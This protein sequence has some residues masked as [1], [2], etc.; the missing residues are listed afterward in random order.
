MTTELVALSIEANDPERQA[1]FWGDLLGWEPADHDDGLAVADH[2]PAIV[3][4]DGTGFRIH[5]PPTDAPKVGQ[6]W[7][8]V[9]L[10]S[11]SLDDQAHQ[12]AR[13]LELGG[14]HVDIGQ[15]PDDGHVV[16]ADPEGNELC[17]I[18]PGNTFLA[19]CPFI[20]ALSC[21]GS[22]AVG[23]FWS[24]ALGWPLVWDQD[25]ETAIQ[26]PHGGPKISWGGPPLNPRL[27][28][29]GIH[30]DLAVPPGDDVRLE[31]DRLVSL[32]ATPTG[33][34]PADRRS[35]LLED[36]DGNGFCVV[37]GARP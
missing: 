22:Q 21:D 4:T 32:G 6:N 16:L 37:E 27:G 10:T 14:R 7:L 13:V 15:D 29:R 33:R 30:L 20:G 24:R 35:V 3:P 25:E 1:R 2:G 8:H 17:V 12:V 18:E 23:Y 36:P 28:R 11:Q 31:V 5:F 19:G 9:D 26:A 34:P